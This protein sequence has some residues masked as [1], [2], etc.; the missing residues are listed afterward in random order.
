MPDPAE[1]TGTEVAERP[2]SRLS[3]DPKIVSQVEKTLS[4]FVDDVD[5]TIP[6]APKLEKPV[7]KEV[8]TPEAEEKVEEAP[9]AEPKKVEE[10]AA[11]ADAPTLPD[12]YRRTAKGYEWTDAE[13]DRLWKADPE[14]AMRTFTKLHESRTKQIGEWADLGRKARQTVP[15]A[16]TEMPAPAAAVDLKPVDIKALIEKY[17]NDDLIAALAGPVNAQI[18]A[19]RPILEQA[20]VAQQIAARQQGEVLGKLV[21]DFFT[22][23]P[24]EQFKESYGGDWASLTADQTKA[25]NNVLEMADALVAG[26]KQ[27]GR[28]LTVNEALQMAHDT[29][30]KD[31]IEQLVRDGIKKSVVQRGKGLTLKPSNTGRVSADAP[32]KNR[33]EAEEHARTRLAEVFT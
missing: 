8:E 30:S 18:E 25:R 1:K 11:S 12:A 4:E 5:G 2:G 23:K 15:V 3:D 10:A 32:A 13:I 31:R 19:L 33:R 20:K 28:N 16:K 9:K 6:P 26:A 17:G 14:M 21:Q 7:E 27:Q 29:V 22:G 24:M